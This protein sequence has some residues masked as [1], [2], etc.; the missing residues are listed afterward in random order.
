MVN[1]YISAKLRKKTDILLRTHEKSIAHTDF[2]YME[3]LP[4]LL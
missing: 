2:Y 4:P 1:S 3:H